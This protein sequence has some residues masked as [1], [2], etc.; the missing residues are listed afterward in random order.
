VH[1]TGI[2]FLENA[3]MRGPTP[4]A[5]CLP[6]A[7]CQ[8][9]EQFVRRHTT[10][11]QKALRARVVLLAGAGAN[12]AQIARQ[13]GLA[14]ATVRYWRERWLQWASVPLEA[15]PLSERF[16]D[17]PRPGAPTKISAEAWC[18]ITALACE[19]PEQSGRPISEWSSRELADEACKRGLVETI[20][21]R[22]VGRFLKR[23][24][25]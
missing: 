7:V 6:E 1:N 22:H 19:P 13:L 11:Q 4:S 21:P 12:N 15:M 23:S 20:S 24:R 5:V 9:L 16:E 10:P 3:R 8:A 18:Q 14:R 17:Q 25:S 2:P